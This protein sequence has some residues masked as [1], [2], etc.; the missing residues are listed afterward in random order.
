MAEEYWDNVGIEKR[1]DVVGKGE[2]RNRENNINIAFYKI[3]IKV[4]QVDI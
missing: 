3:L 1:I 2:T 4:V